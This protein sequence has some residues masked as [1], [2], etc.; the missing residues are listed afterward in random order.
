MIGGCGRSVGARPAVILVRAMSIDVASE[1]L[2]ECLE[3]LAKLHSD[4]HLDDEEYRAAKAM[5]LALAERFGGTTSYN[6]DSA[7]VSAGGVVH[8]LSQLAVMGV[9]WVE[10][11]VAVFAIIAVRVWV[12]R[13][14]VQLSC[15][16]VSQRGESRRHGPCR[17]PVRALTSGYW[18]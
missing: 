9:L 3:R 15:I 16:D 6:I 2:E 5:V 4:G 13:N 10:Y 8:H 7:C 18:G 11:A 17:L 14:A 12:S 1:R